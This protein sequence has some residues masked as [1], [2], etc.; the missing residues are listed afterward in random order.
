MSGQGTDKERLSALIDA[1]LADLEQ[2]V[3]GGEAPSTGE[4][5]ATRRLVEWVERDREF[6]RARELTTRRRAA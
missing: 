4:L 1:K 2:R 6:E 3:A 5:N